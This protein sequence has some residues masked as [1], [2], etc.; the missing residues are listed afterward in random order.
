MY[1]D[2]VD[3]GELK[4]DPNQVAVLEY[5]EDWGT[6]FIKH[7]KQ[8]IQF[9]DKM[10]PLFDYGENAPQAVSAKQFAE[11]DTFMDENTGKRALDTNQKRRAQIR[12]DFSE[13]DVVKNSYIHGEPGG[14]KSFMVDLFYNSLDL[15]KRKKKL[16]YNEFMLM[17][18]EMEHEIN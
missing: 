2:L 4:H 11:Y 18:H 1:Q 16:H 14:G 10:E 9:K 15:G 8:I 17:M 6:Q 3:K 12:Q 13:L 7:E 5:L